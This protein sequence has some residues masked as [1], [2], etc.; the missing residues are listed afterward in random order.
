MF[1]S[2]VR[3]CRA[4]A[5]MLASL[6]KKVERERLVTGATHFEDH[7]RQVRLFWLDGDYWFSFLAVVRLCGGTIIYRKRILRR[8]DDET[9]TTAPDGRT[10]K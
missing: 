6:R 1:R 9:G 2:T 7:W 3:Y 4:R 8:D 5:F 10:S